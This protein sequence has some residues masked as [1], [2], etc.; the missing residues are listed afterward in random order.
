MKLT[1]TLALAGLLAASGAQAASGLLPDYMGFNVGQ[2][3]V[4]IPGDA[5]A[6]TPNVGTTIVTNSLTKS[7]SS[8]SY[9]LYGGYQISDWLAVELGYADLGSFSATR[10]VTTLPAAPTGTFFTTVVGKS[11]GVYF[12]GVGSFKI[13]DSFSLLGR[14]GYGYFSTSVSNISNATA[15]TGPL[16]GKTIAKGLEYGLGAQF[17][18]SK[19]VALR[20]EWEQRTSAYIIGDKSVGIDNISL[21]LVYKF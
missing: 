10:T 17:N 15:V 8:T 1:S 13:N 20:A 9:K 14:L 2:A 11:S 7:S 12:D 5:L 6:M 4:D 16:F 18:F 19:S 21:G 3:K